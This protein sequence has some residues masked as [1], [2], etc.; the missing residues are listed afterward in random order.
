MEPNKGFQDNQDYFA[1]NL[2]YN[3]NVKSSSFVKQ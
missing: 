2:M 1:K 3:V